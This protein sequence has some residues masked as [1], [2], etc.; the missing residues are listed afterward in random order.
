MRSD[1]KITALLSLRAGFHDKFAPGKLYHHVSGRDT[2]T[3]TD[4]EDDTA[5]DT[6][7]TQTGAFPQTLTFTG[8]TGEFAG[9]T[10]ICFGKRVPGNHGLTVS[11]SGTLDA[12]GA[13]EPGS[14]ALLLGGLALLIVQCR[15]RLG[16]RPGIEGRER[17][18]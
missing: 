3:G 15:S 5:I 14:A 6:S 18:A 10:R 2:L 16:Y 7:P 12:L 11:G 1:R 4:L 8:G 9:A 13:P 17:V